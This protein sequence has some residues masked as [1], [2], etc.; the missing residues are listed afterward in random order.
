MHLPQLVTPLCEERKR[1]PNVVSS[2][3]SFGSHSHWVQHSSWGFASPQ[4][5]RWRQQEALPPA[6]NITA[7]LASHAD[8]QEARSPH[9]PAAS[10][11]MLT[12][13]IITVI[14]SKTEN[15]ALWRECQLSPNALSRQHTVRAANLGTARSFISTALAKLELIPK[16]HTHLIIGN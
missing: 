13:L 9:S 16:N 15:D 7:L 10:K 11:K 14:V 6:A 4:L 8:E 3:D 2:K 1:T 12:V 5:E